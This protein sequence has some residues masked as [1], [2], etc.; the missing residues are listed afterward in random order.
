MFALAPWE[1]ASGAPDESGVPPDSGE[2]I[3]ATALLY[4]REFVGCVWDEWPVINK[5]PEPGECD[6][7][8]Y[9]GF[10]H[11]EGGAWIEIQEKS[12]VLIFGRKGLGDN[13]Y[14]NQEDCGGDPCDYSKGY[15]AYPYEPQI[16]FYDPNKFKD[17]ISGTK[18]PWELMPYEVLSPENRFFSGECATLGAAAYDQERALIYVPEQEAGNDGETAVHVWKVVLEQ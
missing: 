17:V 16:L 11:W 4:Y 9:R 5:N 14:G 7:T 10:D 18:E 1:D 13:C 3:D 6:F 8:D 2:E 15:H 12:A